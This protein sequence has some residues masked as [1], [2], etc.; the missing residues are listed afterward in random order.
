MAAQ[1]RVACLGDALALGVAQSRRLVQE[2]WGVLSK[3][4]NRL[5]KLQELVL[6]LTHEVHKDLALPTA[7]AAKAPHDFVQRLL[8]RLGLPCE[9]RGAAAALL[10]DGCDE[11]KGFFCALYSVVASVTR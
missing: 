10:R 3:G 11:R 4:S 7:L 2:L 8:D 6:R 5:A 9:P 1:R